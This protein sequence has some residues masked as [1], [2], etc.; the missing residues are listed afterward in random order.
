MLDILSIVETARE[1]GVSPAI[2]SRA[3]YSGRLSRED[4][5]RIAGRTI[6][7]RDYVEHVVKPLLRRQGYHIPRTEVSAH[8]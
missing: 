4:C 6:L 3:F 2:I 8:A 7:M 1:C 5:P